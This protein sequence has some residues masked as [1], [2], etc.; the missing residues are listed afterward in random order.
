MSNVTSP[1][2][3]PAAS[4]TGAGGKSPKGGAKMSDMKLD[5]EAFNPPPRDGSGADS[6]T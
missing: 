2:A 4:P 1:P 3:S 5:G 6:P